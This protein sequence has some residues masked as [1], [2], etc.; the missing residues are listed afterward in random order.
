[1]SS[2]IFCRIVDGGIPAKIVYQDEQ[3]VAFED[4][5]PQAP[6]HVLVIPKRHIVSV[7]DCHKV[8]EA[9][10]GHLLL[11]CAKVAGIKHVAESGY[12]VV[13][14]TGADSGQSVFHLHLHVLGGRPLA[15]PPG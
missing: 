9:L 12:R 2:C 1:M 5:N 14:N 7:K 11:T 15:W 4:V 6:V 13:T 8:D 3:A 10:L